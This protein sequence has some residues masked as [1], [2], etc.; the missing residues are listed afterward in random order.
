MNV[1]LRALKWIPSQLW[2]EIKKSPL[3]GIV[4]VAAALLVYKQCEN[5]RN[6]EQAR[7]R[8]A[9]LSRQ[10]ASAQDTIEV[11]ENLYAVSVVEIEN[12]QRVIE[13]HGESVKALLDQLQET[14]DRLLA[15][16]ALVV[17]WK[18]AYEGALEASQSEEEGEG[19]VVRKRV[20]F[21]KEWGYIG[22]TGHTLTDPPEGYITVSQL[23]PLRLTV[24]VAKGSDG[25][26][27]AYVHSSE[28]NVQIDIDLAAVDV[29]VALPKKTW[30]DRLWIDGYVGL[31]GETSAGV[32]ASYRFDR[33][34]F[35]VFCGQ[36][37]SGASCGLSAGFR[38]F[39]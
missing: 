36:S 27:R 29:E 30:R 34:S 5:R 2:T 8:S 24:G 16:Q 33:Y 32:G 39:R 6:L 10:L 21:K 38:P 26:W 23:R 22:V 31:L 19:G 14:E 20:D 28:E 35:G 3:F 13:E 25:Q 37:E 9:E 17:K 1:V 7:E 15:T 11:K 4:L 12:L 18:K